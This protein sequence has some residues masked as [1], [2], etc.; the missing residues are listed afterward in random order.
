MATPDQLTSAQR[1]Q[2]YTLAA[3]TA[4]RLANE[5]N[6]QAYTFIAQAGDLDGVEGMEPVREG[7]LARAAEAARDAQVRNHLASIYAWLSQN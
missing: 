5:K 6:E 2:H 3:T 4:T 7:H 1:E